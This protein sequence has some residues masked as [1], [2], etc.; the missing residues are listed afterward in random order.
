[1]KTAFFAVFAQSQSSIVFKCMQMNPDTS[2]GAQSWN[3]ANAVLY[4]TNMAASHFL[5]EWQWDDSVAPL[6]PKLRTAKMNEVV[7]IAPRRN[8]GEFA[9]EAMLRKTKSFCTE[10]HAGLQGDPGTAMHFAGLI[11]CQGSEQSAH[12]GE[13]RYAETLA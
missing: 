7:M 9:L 3:I 12:E 13:V 10:W 5:D 6:G 11:A 8:R 4:A 1:M 2:A